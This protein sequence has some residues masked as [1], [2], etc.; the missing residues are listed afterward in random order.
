[1][2]DLNHL[3]RELHR[4]AGL[5]LERGETL[6]ARAYTAP[7]FHAR[8]QERIF[9]RDWICVGRAE[10]LP[11]PG[12]YLRVDD[13]GVPLV[14]TRDEDGTPHA[15]SRVC[16]H[17]FMDVLPPETTP[18]QGT[19]KRLTC[20]YHTWTYRLNGEFAGRLAGSPLMHRVEFDRAACRLPGHRVEVWNG[21][22]MVNLDP[23]AEPLAPQLSGLDE[24]LAPYGL[25]A[26][27]TAYTLR[28]NG[29]PANWKVAV[30]NGSEN[31]HH[32]GTHAATL[33]PLL[34]GRDTVIDTCDG[35]WFTMYTPFAA[36]AVAAGAES[37][38][39]PAALIPGTAGAAGE[40]GMLIAGVFPHLVMAV[41]PDSVTV[42]RWL[43]T[44]PDRHDAVAT[45]LTT[46]A[47]RE[48]PGFEAWAEE[49]RSS[50][51]LIQGEDLVA[52]RGVQRGL[53]TDPAPSGGR[54]SHLER[55]LWQFQRYLDRRLNGP[56]PA[57]T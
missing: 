26:L 33:E 18:A 39:D 31:Y 20:P 29:V 10:D 49:S 53:A 35:R 40:A 16:R 50:L 42:L 6:P 34:P 55:P 44:G 37:P 21:F 12:S 28:W 13:L 41:V 11:G 14:L 51:E 2:T 45:V 48:R 25:G 30:E 27:Q 54:F 22:L 3:L 52:V 47:A 56:G 36:G 1:M 32:M 43:P 38:P 4:L 5:P 17:R 7:E 23:D 57:G 24:R 15:L 9:R 19:L 8:E 46:A